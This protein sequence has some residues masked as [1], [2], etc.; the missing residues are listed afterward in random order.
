MEAMDAMTASQML[1][2]KIGTC[3]QIP[4]IQLRRSINCCLVEIFWSVAHLP[5]LRPDSGQKV[6]GERLDHGRL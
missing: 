4:S 1:A 3:L 6:T 5:W 2:G